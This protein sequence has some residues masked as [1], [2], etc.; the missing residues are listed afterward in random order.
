MIVIGILVGAVSMMIGFGF[1]LASFAGVI[2]ILSVDSA[3]M[4][5][6]YL[7]TAAFALILGFLLIAL[8][9]FI[10]WRYST[11]R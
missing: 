3:D 8:P 4:Q 1:V 7:Q 5:V 10:A 6:E 9:V 2:A 11:P